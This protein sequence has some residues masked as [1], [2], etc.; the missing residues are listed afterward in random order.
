MDLTLLRTFQRQVLNQ[1]EFLLFAAEDV[2]VSLHA[3][4]TTRVFYALQNLLN[5]AANISKALW[6][7]GGRFAAQRQAL[8]DSIGISDASPLRVVTMRNNFEHFDERLDKW[9]NES[10][11]HNNVDFN[12]GH[13]YAF[14][15]H[16][17]IDFFRNFDPQNGELY[18]WSQEF[19]IPELITEVQRILPTLRAEVDKPH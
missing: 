12:I 6:G 13:K 1:C 14:G 9:W 11:R 19:N 16:D 2:N 15:H 5:A 10:Q 17:P 7:Q 8:R 4:N 3:H 18:F